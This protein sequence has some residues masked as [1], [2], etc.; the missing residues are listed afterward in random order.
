[1]FVM[2]IR[3]VLSIAIFFN[4]VSMIF[5]QY[6]GT[7]LSQTSKFFRVTLAPKDQYSSCSEKGCNLCAAPT[8]AMVVIVPRCNVESCQVGDL[9]VVSMPVINEAIAAVIVFLIPL[10]GAA[11]TALILNFVVGMSLESGT[12]VMIILTAFILCFSIPIIIDRRIKKRYPIT[13]RKH[14]VTC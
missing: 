1:M 6:M 13:V 12:A 7:I 10:I 2:E 9:V 5:K 4:G 14:D 11:I 3:L 8:K